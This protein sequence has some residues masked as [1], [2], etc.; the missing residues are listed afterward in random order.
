MFHFY[1]PWKRHETFGFLAFP[2]ATEMEIDQKGL[3]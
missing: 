2:G 3:M 1:T